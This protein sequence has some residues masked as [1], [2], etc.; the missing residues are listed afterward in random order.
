MTPR[1]EKLVDIAV[2]VAGLSAALIAVL[3]ISQHLVENGRNRE[4]TSVGIVEDWEKYASA[5]RRTGSETA[6]A[7]IIEF[8]DYQCP[9]C[10][11]L[12]PHI[13]AILRQFPADVA[14]VFRHFPLDE[15]SYAAARAAECAGEQG[16]FWEFHR[17]LL[18]NANWFGNAIGQLAAAAGVRDMDAF[19]ECSTDES[20]VPAIED[21]L[22]A[23]LEL[24]AQGTPTILIN[25][26]MSYGV[27]DSLRLAT[28]IRA[29]V[30]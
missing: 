4:V 3:L 29:A 12:Q 20:P 27:I 17:E 18:S 14:F 25:G 9:Y 5:G 19:D 23:A 11:D 8:G 24:G 16:R 30:P 1:L 15:V 26:E 21:D 22:A 10:R 7:T 6:G 13:D 28:A 2:I